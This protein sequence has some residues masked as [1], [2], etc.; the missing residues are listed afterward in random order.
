MSS[1]Y[2]SALDNLLN[3]SATDSL[4]SSVVPHHLQHANANDAIEA[5][6]TVLG[7]LPA[8]SFLTVK[9]RIE[10]YEALNGLKDVTITNVA[11]GDILRYNGSKWS[12]YAEYEITDGGNF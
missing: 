7:V 8:G 4:N 9:D 6:Q 3:P 2:P 11:N 5:I 1:N 10:A 12:N